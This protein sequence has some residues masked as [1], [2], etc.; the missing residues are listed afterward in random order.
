VRERETLPFDESLLSGYVDGVLTQADRQRVEIEVS[1]SSEAQAMLD[2]LR[3]MR[4]AARSTRFRVPEDRSWDERPRTRVSAWSRSA[5]WIVTGAWAVGLV[6]LGV[7][8][9]LHRGGL[10]GTL[11]LGGLAGAALLFG[12][13]LADRLRDLPHD[14]YRRVLK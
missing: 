5:G 6:A 8:E 11:M 13:V 14:R 9:L 3:S 12:S 1:R 10:T 4:D 2:Q 7:I